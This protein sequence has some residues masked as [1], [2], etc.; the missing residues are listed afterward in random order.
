MF[1]TYLEPKLL[2]DD[3]ELIQMHT[4]EEDEKIRKEEIPE[5]LPIL[6]LRNTVLYPG[7]VIPITVGREKSIRLVKDA[8]KKDK[9]IGVIAQ[10]EAGVEEPGLKDI[11]EVGTVALIKRVIKMDKSSN[12]TIVIQGRRKFRLQQV[13]QE[14]P[15]IK[16]KVIPLD[17]QDQG[18]DKESV[19]LM[20]DIKAVSTSIIELSPHLPTEATMILKQINIPTFLINF[21]INNLNLDVTG[22]QEILEMDSFKLKAKIVLKHLNEE[23]QM[24][25][26]KN[27][28]QAKVHSDLDEQQRQFLLTQQ[29]KTIQ[30]ELGADGPDHEIKRLRDQ[31]AKKKWSETVEETFNKELEK[32]QRMNPAIP[33]YTVTLNYLELLLDLPWESYTKDKFDLGYSKRVLDKDHYGLEKVKTRILEYL[34]VLKLKGDMKSP[35][36]CFV[37]PP[38]TGKTSLGKSI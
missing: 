38:G 19:K 33:D 30:E 4:E 2:Q 17:E 28:I 16:A 1:D 21:I 13:T 9:I 3:V 27:E 31:A 5:E 10:K 29:L 22:K 35:I 34:A 37:G 14:E 12:V 23:F 6:P 25:Q 18:K 36:L 24:L 20:E 11:Y 26:L 32:L 15:Y 8:E 7:V